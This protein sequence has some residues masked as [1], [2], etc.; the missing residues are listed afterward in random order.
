LIET[1]GTFTT[2]AAKGLSAPLF[3]R[4]TLED[5]TAGA[6]DV[7]EKNIVLGFT[8]KLDSPMTV[9]DAVI[10]TGAQTVGL[11]QLTVSFPR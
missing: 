9:S 8:L 5:C 6:A 3:E 1:P 2:V 11:K 10:S 4:M 7:V